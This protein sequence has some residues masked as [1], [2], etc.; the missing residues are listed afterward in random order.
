MSDANSEDSNAAVH[1]SDQSTPPSSVEQ[2][3]PS[4]PDTE[5]LELLEEQPAASTSTHSNENPSTSAQSKPSKRTFNDVME[6]LKD[7]FQQSTKKK[8][9]EL[10]AQIMKEALKEDNS[11]RLVK[12]LDLLAI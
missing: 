1:G 7:I 9:K 11:D 2:E 12:E 8:R 5:H 6:D 4:I 3:V 10:V